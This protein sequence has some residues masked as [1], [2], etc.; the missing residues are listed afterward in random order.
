MPRRL[1]KRVLPSPHGL[2]DHWVLRRFGG[3]LADPALWA[4][5]RRAVAGAF[6]AGLAICFIPLPVH[7]PVAALAAVTWRLNIPMA[8]ATTFIVNPVTAVPVFYAAYRVGAFLLAYDPQPFAFEPSWDW[9][10][11]GLGP[12]WRPFLLGCLVCGTVAGVAGRL[13]LDVAWRVSVRKRYRTRR[14]TSTL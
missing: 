2:K 11:H 13:A 7:L 12:K 9:L 8:I 6:G 5:H 14:G 4:L 1:F 3:W 10:A